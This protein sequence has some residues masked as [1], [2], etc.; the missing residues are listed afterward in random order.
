[1]RIEDYPPQEPFSGLGEA[2]HAAVMERGAG[3]AAID[4]S[5]GDDPYQGIALHVPAKPNGTVL[6][7][8][9]GGGWTNG[10]KEWMAFMAPSLTAQGILF[11]SIGYRL[12]PQNVFPAGFDDA[13]DG[14]AALHKSVADYGGDP[15]RIFVGGHS[16]GGHYTALLA[17]RDDWQAPRGLPSH[18][19]RGCLPVSGVFD[20]TE[21]SGL[22]MR[23]RFLGATGTELAASP[24]HSIA[25][26]PPPFLIAHGNSD[27][28]HLIHQASAMEEALAAA[29]GAVERI[30]LEGRDHLGASYACAEADAIW[31]PRAV[32]L[33]SAH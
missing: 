8:M 5:Y 16:A 2:Y 14:V 4:I 21:T 23:P 9:H 1:M 19:V 13:A 15:S 18:I 31:L 32:A 10:Y 33:M 11:A 12:A 7:F 26:T 20:F 3:I 27:F 6:A 30:E 25:G 22:S 28:P 29:G 24:I 17:V